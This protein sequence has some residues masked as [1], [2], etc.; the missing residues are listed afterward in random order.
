MSSKV[1]TNGYLFQ[2]NE[3]YEQ[4]NDAFINVII[5]IRNLS[6]NINSPFKNY[7]AIQSQHN[8]I[9]KPITID[10]QKI[11]FSVV[12]LLPFYCKLQRVTF[13]SSFRH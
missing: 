1:E 2:F 6:L 10:S 7:N 11:W 3:I 4:C 8:I 9:S 5:I 13:F 12:F